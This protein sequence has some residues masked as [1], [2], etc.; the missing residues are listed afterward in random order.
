[1]ALSTLI[2]KTWRRLAVLALALPLVACD[3]GMNSMVAYYDLPPAERQEFIRQTFGE[4]KQIGAFIS[5]EMILGTSALYISFDEFRALVVDEESLLRYGLGL[6]LAR[7]PILPTSGCHL[8]CGR[9]SPRTGST[10]IARGALTFSTSC[11]RGG[12]PLSRRARGALSQA[13]QSH[14]RGDAGGHHQLLSRADPG[15]RPIQRAADGRQVCTRLDRQGVRRAPAAQQRKLARHAGAGADPRVAGYRK[16]TS[17][18]L[19][20]LKVFATGRDA[21]RLRAASDSLGTGR[22]SRL[23]RVAAAALAA[24]ANRS[25]KA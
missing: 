19:P 1:M 7:F 4:G 13:G 6:Y 8:W 20:G 10:S 16:L 18:L 25:S 9:G 21:G 23:L 17:P 24:R 5:G 22:G 3:V 15:H 2:K 14:D 12:E 11:S